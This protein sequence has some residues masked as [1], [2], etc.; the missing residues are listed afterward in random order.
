MLYPSINLLRTKVDSKYTLV[1]MASKRARDIIDGKP[2]LVDDPAINKPVSIAT[3]E[4]AE[5]KITYSRS[6]KTEQEALEIEHEHYMDAHNAAEAAAH[7]AEASA[8]SDAGEEAES[9]EEIQS[10][11]QEAAPEA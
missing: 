1:A 2:V 4:I 5:D 11:A 6:F 10:E 7:A 9:A 3:E 8:V